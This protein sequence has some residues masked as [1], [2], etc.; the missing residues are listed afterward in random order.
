M[1]IGAVH[2]LDTTIT[3]QYL[4]NILA[5]LEG[6]PIG[7]ELLA[8]HVLASESYARK[9]MQ[10]RGM[11]VMDMDDIEV[12]EETGDITSVDIEEVPDGTTSMLVSPDEPSEQSTDDGTESTVDDMMG[13]LD[14]L[15][16]HSMTYHDADIAE[17]YAQI[18]RTIVNDPESFHLDKVHADTLIEKSVFDSMPKR[19]R[20]W[21]G[22]L[23]EIID[24]T[25]SPFVRKKIQ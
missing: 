23:E 15:L 7:R 12:G 5:L 19:L 16:Y 21:Y 20:D 8:E 6:H 9:W 24:D 14:M 10:G 11:S 1:E 13:T 22:K 17:L 2:L 25:Y 4:E 18:A 3:V